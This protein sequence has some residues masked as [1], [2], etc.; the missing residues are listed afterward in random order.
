VNLFD[1]NCKYGDVMFVDEVV[2]YISRAKADKT[3]REVAPMLGV[4]ASS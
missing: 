4:G 2:D 3:Q 1:M